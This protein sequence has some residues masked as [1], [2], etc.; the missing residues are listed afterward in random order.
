MPEFQLQIFT[1]HVH[2]GFLPQKMAFFS[3]TLTC[4]T[5]IWEQNQQNNN[6]FS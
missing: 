1:V 5:Q 3:S 2:V 4:I 6:N